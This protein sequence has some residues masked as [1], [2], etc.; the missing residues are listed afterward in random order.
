LKQ[1]I[2]RTVETTTYNVGQDRIL[3]NLCRTV[4]GGIRG[5]LLTQI[6]STC[7]CVLLIHSVMHKI[8]ENVT[9]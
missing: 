3:P 6:L 5:I 2:T 8:Y 7:R 9:L 4:T 1:R